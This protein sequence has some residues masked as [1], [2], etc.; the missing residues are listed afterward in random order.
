M[1]RTSQ[2]ENPK[3]QYTSVYAPYTLSAI[4]TVAP[5]LWPPALTSPLLSYQTTKEDVSALASLLQS[6]GSKSGYAPANHSEASL[7]P[8][9]PNITYIPNHE[10][11]SPALRS[12]GTGLIAPSPFCPTP[13]QPVFPDETQ[14]ELDLDDVLD[15]LTDKTSFDQIQQEDLWI[16]QDHPKPSG[17]E[18]I[19]AQATRRGSKRPRIDTSTSNT[20]T[21]PLEV[22]LPVDNVLT[23]CQ[24]VL[25]KDLTASDTGRLGRVV[26]PRGQVEA[27]FSEAVF[28]SRDGLPL[29]VY[30]LKSGKKHVLKLKF[31][32]NGSPVPKRMWL[33]DGTKELMRGYKAGNRF[34]LYKAVNGAYIVDVN[35]M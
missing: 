14:I 9:T 33:F 4:P 21:H 28:S 5:C 8:H 25:S 34:A 7:Q 6:L 17:Q 16:F 18:D 10:L 19:P 31:W 26:L 22:I 1:I 20:S 23:P 11:P 12:T 35:S 3:P 29:T 13:C 15:F 24:F 2:D 27:H 30:D 32:L